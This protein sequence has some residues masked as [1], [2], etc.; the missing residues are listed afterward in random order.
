MPNNTSAPSIHSRLKRAVAPW[1]AVALCFAAFSTAG[2]ADA[3]PKYGPKATP[4]FLDHGYFQKAAAGNFWRLMPFYVPQSNEYACSA[5]SIAMI[6]NTATKGRAG[7]AE[8]ERNITQEW[9]LERVREVPLRE[10]VSKEGLRGRHGLTLDELRNAVGQTARVLG[11][12]AQVAACLFQNR[13]VEEFRKILRANET[14][15]A[16]FLLVHFVQDDLTGARG[17]PYAH[18]SPIGAYDDTTRR[19]LILDVDR[20]WYSP[21]WVSDEDLLAACNHVTKPLGAGGLIHV[22]F[23][24]AGGTP[25]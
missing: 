17:G 9:L 8:T 5:A 15:P 25:R 21:Y 4:L 19:V 10:L 2:A 3:R 11:V 12:R 23:D 16:D 22:R 7:I 14:D 24:P 20:E 6:F 1:I 18:I 13:P